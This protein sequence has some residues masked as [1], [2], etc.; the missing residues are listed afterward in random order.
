[1]LWAANSLSIL[2]ELPNLSS[3]HVNCTDSRKR[4]VLAQRNEWWHAKFCQKASG[5]EIILRGRRFL[6]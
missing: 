3:C 2:P 1:M 4:N 5:E 6:R